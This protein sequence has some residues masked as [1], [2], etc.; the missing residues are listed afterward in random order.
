MKNQ[1]LLFIFSALFSGILIMS[2]P[3]MVSAGPLS[4]GPVVRVSGT[5]R[6][7]AGGETLGGKRFSYTEW[8][9]AGMTRSDMFGI[10]ILT[11]SGHSYCY[12]IDRSAKIVYK[13]K[14][15]SA[16][17]GFQPLASQAL[18]ALD[19]SSPLNGKAIV[20]LGHR[21]RLSMAF[22]DIKDNSGYIVFSSGVVHGV[23]VRMFFEAATP[24][25]HFIEHATSI[26][27]C[28]HVPSGLMDLPKGY[29]IVEI[30]EKDG[31]AKETSLMAKAVSP[32]IP[33]YIRKSVSSAAPPA[34]APPAAAAPAA[35]SL[36]SVTAPPNIP[37]EFAYWS[38]GRGWS[39]ALKGSVVRLPDGTTITTTKEPQ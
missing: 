30:N 3:Q 13:F 6:I 38:T 26:I 29:E 21:C 5:C 39:Y 11:K 28:K 37:G 18:K 16:E 19:F 36:P 24:N 23:S 1:R 20:Y 33:L 2:I 35:A 32:L 12:L 10:T 15:Q 7:T 14:D 22:M 17:E 4:N 31:A 27:V 8:D 34:S 25:M 9:S